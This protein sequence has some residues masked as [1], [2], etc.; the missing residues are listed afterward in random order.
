MYKQKQLIRRRKDETA[1]QH[2]ER[3]A[4]ERDKEAALIT[5]ADEAFIN[6]LTEETEG[7][8]PAPSTSKAEQALTDVRMELAEI[9]LRLATAVKEKEEAEAETEDFSLSFNKEQKRCRDLIERSQH[10]SDVADELQMFKRDVADNLGYADY[11]VCPKAETL[12]PLI[13][14][15]RVKAHKWDI[16]AALQQERW[17]F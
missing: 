9:K 1:K 11:L 5:K 6:D 17:R 2:A 15:H 8:S 13:K 10:L 14:Q 12:I 16:E 7:I 3:K 4:E